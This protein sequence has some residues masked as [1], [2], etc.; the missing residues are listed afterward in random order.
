MTKE[1]KY[2]WI[3]DLKLVAKTE[4]Y[5]SYLYRNGVW[6][7][8][9]CH[10]VNDRLMG[11]MPGEGIGNTDMLMKIDEIS[12]EEA[13]K[14][15]GISTGKKKEIMLNRMY[16]GDFLTTGDN[17]GHEVINLFQDDNGRNYIYVLSDGTVA[18][19]HNN[20]VQIIYL[21][22]FIGNNTME[23]LAKA[24]ELTQIICRK[25]SGR[26][27]RAEIHQQQIQYI[28]DNN[29]TYGGIPLDRLYKGNIYHGEIEE[30]AL[31]VTYETRKMRKP[32]SPIYITDKE[33]DSSK[34][35]EFFLEGIT[36]AKQSPK[37]YY[38][39]GTN[40]YVVLEQIAADDSLWENDNTTEKIRPEDHAEDEQFNFLKLIRKEYDEI[41]FSNLFEHY[42]SYNPRIFAA[43]CRQ[44]LGG[45][46]IS[47][48]YTITRESEKN[49]DL[50][51]QDY[52]NVIVIENKIKSNINGIRH[53]IY[54]K[55]IQSQ[56]SKY[57]EHAVKLSQNR[58]EVRCFIFSPDYNYLDIHRFKDAKRY[59]IIEYSK[60]YEFFNQHKEAFSEDKYFSDF[61]S[62]LHKH[63]HKVD[64]EL[65]EEMR[66]K[67]SRRI[68]AL[69]SKKNLSESA[70]EIL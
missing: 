56:L 63:T 6:E 55:E 45:I 35:K 40:A 69:N 19:E 49:I 20:R 36:F 44:V 62:A 34:E 50:L 23:I 22:R 67:F 24:E 28:S 57:Y 10:I 5:E 31:Y 9:R 13:E 42:F 48:S 60:I 32:V 29:I 37:M 65:Y 2:Y 8:D 58:R 53:D 51:V 3:N 18:K 54:S 30:D 25:S 59:M 61:L 47:E 43:F 68:L 12:L 39:E 7:V 21:V 27:E 16:S 70:G 1:L 46:E 26:R 64:N 14:K 41:V 33:K 38:Q 52:M 66:R 11:Y 17:I 4:N 15:M